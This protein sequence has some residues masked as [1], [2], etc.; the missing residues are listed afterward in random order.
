VS[1]QAGSAMKNDPV[2]D[3]SDE[4]VSATTCAVLLAAGGGSR[5]RGP[6]HKLVALLRSRPVYQWALDALRPA[7]FAHV[8]VVTGSIELDLP[9]WVIHV[10]NSRWATGQASS[11]QCA[12][13]VARAHDAEAVVVGLGDQP[14]ITTEAWMAL[15]AAK[16]PIA[17]AT[18]HTER[19]HPVRL[20]RSVWSQLATEGDQGARS[21]MVL[22]PDLVGEVACQGS[23][24]DIDTM[25][26]LQQWNSSTNSP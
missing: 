14:F 4:C 19:G 5:F 17:V 20:H 24:A 3:T 21:L 1:W 10:H 26:D 23:A 7:R 9:D 16:T 15:A 6:S 2:D 18:Y 13:A 12:L 8:I 22:R 11:L 25:E